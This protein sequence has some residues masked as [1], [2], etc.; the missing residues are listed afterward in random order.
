M[1]VGSFPTYLDHG[2]KFWAFFRRG[3]SGLNG[4]TQSFSARVADHFHVFFQAIG[5]ERFGDV[6]SNAAGLRLGIP[7]AE[8]ERIVQRLAWR[9]MRGSDRAGLG[10]VVRVLEQDGAASRHSRAG[11][12][13]V[14]LSFSDRRRCHS[15]ENSLGVDSDGRPL[16]RF[17]NS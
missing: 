1:Q 3:G 16:A 4:A 10:V 2:R 17:D 11:A 6:G 7:P 5:L 12:A 15:L 8:E 9:G 14:L 13:S